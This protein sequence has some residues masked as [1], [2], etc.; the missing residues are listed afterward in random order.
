MQNTLIGGL[1]GDALTTG[2]GNTG[3]GYNVAF[4]AN[5]ASNQTVIGNGAVGH[6]DN[7]IVLGNTSVASIEPGVNT[8]SLGSSS[9]PFQDLYL[10]RQIQLRT[11]SS[12]LTISQFD[13]N[14][15]ARVHDGGATLSDTDMSAIGY[16]FGFKMPV[17]SVDANS[18]DKTVTLTAA[19]SG[20][21]IQC[22]A[23]THNVIFNLP[24]IDAANKAGLTYTFV[25]TTAVDSG[26]TIK[27]QTSGTDNN[28]KFLMYGFNGATSI[29]DVGGDVITIPNSAAIG[30]VVRIT[31]LGS[32]A[33]NAAEIWLAEVFGESEVLN[34]VS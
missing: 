14:E 32:G 1:A 10:G 13:G 18:A 7:I 12:D 25:N 34:D 22:D 33:S 19:E 20:S 30:T 28:D 29:R 6:G 2:S 31:C 11:N 8:A 16:G 21:I 4:S 27:I 17:L 5:S 26:H 24:V 15:V 9:Y 23:D 3:L